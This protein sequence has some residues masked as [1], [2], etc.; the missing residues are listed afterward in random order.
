MR[1]DISDKLIHFTGPREDWE[2]AYSRLQSIMIERRIRGGNRFIKGG[3]FCVCFTEAPL[4]LEGLV[5]PSGYS[6]YAPFGIMIE[7]NWLFTQG[8]R[9][10][11]YQPDFEFDILPQ[12]IRWRHVRYEP[13]EQEV[14][15]FSW[16]REWRI[17]TNEL[18]ISP[19]VAVVILPDEG[20]AERIIED[21]DME[22]ED[23]IL[24]YSLVLD[25]HIAEQYREG[26][27]WTIY[28]PEKNA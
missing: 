1:K 19:E 9:P 20:W 8:G 22:E 2:E 23:R 10:V 14:V 7:K 21:H 4:R 12:E 5:N 17:Q 16:E 18:C 3:E 15:D 24:M 28:I 13:T 26:F 27:G 6:R 11:I 25:E